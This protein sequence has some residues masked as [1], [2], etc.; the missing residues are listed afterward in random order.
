MSTRLRNCKP[1]KCINFKEVYSTLFYISTFSFLTPL[2]LGA[3][4]FKTLNVSLRVLFV[5]IIISGT[6][7]VLDVLIK[8]K[9]IHGYYLIQNIFPI[10]EFSLLSI[11]YY[12]EFQN[13]ALR[14]TILSVLVIYSFFTIVF[15]SNNE[16]TS[17]PDNVTA[18]ESCILISYTLYFF[19]KVLSDINIP[20]LLNDPFFIFNC[21]VVYYFATSVVLFLCGDYLDHCS[22]ENFQKVWSLHF[23]GNI[24]FNSLLAIVFW[25]ARSK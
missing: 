11:I 4:K 18:I 9:L 23:I 16:I 21:A 6:V 2:I 1:T 22:R 17:L 5:Y 20:N 19:Y 25:K 8:H 24:L 13:K 12:M 3:V 7:E 10:V 15:L 14:K